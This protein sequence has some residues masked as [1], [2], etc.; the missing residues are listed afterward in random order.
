MRRLALIIATAVPLVLPTT[1]AVLAGPVSTPALELSTPVETV[2]HRKGHRPR[3]C[4]RSAQRH[5][6]RGYGR[7]LH[8]HVGPWCRVQVV[9]RHHHRDRGDCIKIGDVRICF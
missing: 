1:P 2:Y 6:V 9:R 5:W 3:H 8:R 4:H 7:V